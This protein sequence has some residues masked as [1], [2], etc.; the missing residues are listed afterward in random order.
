MP[1]GLY[2]QLQ[3]DEHRPMKQHFTEIIADNDLI[4]GDDVRYLK[5]LAKHK[6]WEKF[7][8]HVQKMKKHGINQRRIDA[9]VAQ[10]MNGV[11]L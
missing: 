5:T 11:R 8:S 6:D 2:N 1:R 7:S 9:I 3:G 4:E 10:A